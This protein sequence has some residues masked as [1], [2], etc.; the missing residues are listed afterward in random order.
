MVAGSPVYLS[1]SFG[2]SERVCPE[3]AGGAVQVAVREADAAALEVAT[4]QFSTESSI[5]LARSS[6]TINP[7]MVLKQ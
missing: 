2:A 5:F 7:E 4:T 6:I 1:T 3:K